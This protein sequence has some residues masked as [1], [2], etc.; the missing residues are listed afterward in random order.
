[1]NIASLAMGFA[2]IVVGLL[3]GRLSSSLFGW[4]VIALL[5][6]LLGTASTSYIVGH[7]IGVSSATH[8]FESALRSAVATHRDLSTDT[9][10][11]LLGIPLTVLDKSQGGLWPL[12]VS[13]IMAIFGWTAVVVLGNFHV[14]RVKRAAKLG[15][16]PDRV[17]ITFGKQDS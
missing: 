14:M 1:M 2:L 7:A 4:L 8:A 11:A 16:S 9:R 17:K 3:V 10:F 5:A 15:I 12:L 13:A 6:A